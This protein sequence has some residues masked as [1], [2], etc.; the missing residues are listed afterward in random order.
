MSKRAIRHLG[1]GAAL[2]PL[3]IMGIWCV[4]M[5][6]AFDLHHRD[7]LT[8]DRDLSDFRRHNHAAFIGGSLGR[9]HHLRPFRR[10]IHKQ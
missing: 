10:P 9:R 5:V 8:D 1:V 7:F 3:L 4:W 6:R 2:A